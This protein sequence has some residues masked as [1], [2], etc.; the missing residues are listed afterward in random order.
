M[1]PH[2]KLVM[3][4][5]ATNL[6]CHSHWY[7]WLNNIQICVTKFIIFC[8]WNAYCSLN[9][10]HI[11]KQCHEQ[12]NDTIRNVSIWKPRKLYLGYGDL[13]KCNSCDKYMIFVLFR[14]ASPCYRQWQSSEVLHMEKKMCDVQNT[15]KKLKKNSLSS[16]KITT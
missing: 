2:G 15:W 13:Q 12:N 1:Q 5:E 7:L 16:Q 14:R 9:L 10:Q 11:S 8:N 3:W 6:H 4:G